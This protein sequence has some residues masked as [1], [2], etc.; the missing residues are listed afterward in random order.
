MIMETINPKLADHPCFNKDSRHTSA[1]VHLPVAPRCN[2]QCNFCDRNFSCVNESRPGVTCSVL[3]P[4]QALSYLN[5][6]REKLPTLR[7]VGIA[8][9]GDP[10]ANPDETLETLSMVRAAHPDLLLCVATN[11]L[12]LM[13]YVDQLADLKVARHDYRQRRPTGNRHGCVFLDALRQRHP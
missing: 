6:M 4:R 11:G 8:G 7:V 1:R 5:E 10:F 3:K 2:V 9:P 12:N 13:P